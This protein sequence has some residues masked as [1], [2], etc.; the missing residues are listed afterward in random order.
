MN[1]KREVSK[2]QDKLRKMMEGGE[3][4]LVELA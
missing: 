4:V 3:A 1:Y 2:Q